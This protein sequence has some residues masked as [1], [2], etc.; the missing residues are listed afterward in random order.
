MYMSMPHGY[1]WT[2]RCCGQV[3]K[4]LIWIDAKR[5]LYVGIF[6][7]KETLNSKKHGDAAFRAKD[8]VTA[9]DSYTEVSH[10]FI[11]FDR[12]Q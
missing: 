1:C 6:L 4:G 10:K 3:K 7:I 5:S 12:N 2:N 8:F 11:H 9:I